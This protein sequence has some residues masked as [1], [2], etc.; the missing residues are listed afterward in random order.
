MD[1][2]EVVISALKD[3]DISLKR[4]EIKTAFHDTASSAKNTEW[5]REHLTPDTLLSQEE[6]K[7]YSKLEGSGTLSTLLSDANFDS[8]R[9]LLD[10]DLQ[11]AI[12]VLNTSTAEI[13]RQTG[14]LTTQ[15]DA[16]SRQH[17]R[18]NDRESRQNREMERLR[19]KHDAGR[20]NT[21]AALNE[22]ALELDVSLK[23]E[24]EKSTMDGKK[25]LSALTTR[26]K[27]NDNLLSDLERLATGVKSSDGDV[28][29]MRRMS[30]L[31][32]AL[33][34]Y[35][36]EEIYCRLDRLYLEK[37]LRDNG[38]TSDGPSDK[39]A[40][41]VLGLEQ[42]MDSLY[43][44][45]DVLAEMSTKQQFVEPV[46]RQLQNHYGQLRV[47]SHQKLDFILEAVTD[48]TTSAESLIIS[49]QS[50][51]SFC[52]TL[53][54]FTS[55]YRSE[56]GDQVLDSTSSRRETMRRFS[57]QPTLMASQ[58]GKQSVPSPESEALM[59]L[60][61]RLGL[62]FEAIFQAEEADGGVQSLLQ[63]RQHML[64]GL[65]D[66]GVASDS[67]LAVELLSTDRATRLLSSSLE[68]N[69][70]FTAS[71]SSVEHERSLSEL[72]S[73]LGHIQKGMQRLNQDVVHQRD[74]NQ[75][76]F[77]ERWG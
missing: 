25:I 1:P 8:T 4:D 71:L 68:A 52:A 57:T 34:R 70:L 24:S 30:E 45:I 31:S 56:V 77:L 73:K 11:K 72:E 2:L 7:L 35:V 74:K 28:S 37:I 39:E 75:E 50:R 29:I 15:Y 67:Q 49:L 44:E 59:R 47:V 19:R 36:T 42:E 32:T 6:L 20:Q 9:P 61:R 65:H 12:E 23:N 53:E 38:A 40:E 10:E 17:K 5:V 64:D 63:K 3:R 51:E 60:L 48:M 21:A 13:Q 66:Y 58:P 54:T 14:I 55:T 16:L 27:E 76:K 43:P 33:A 41:T 22:L 26:L 69:S 18:D 62:S 46:L